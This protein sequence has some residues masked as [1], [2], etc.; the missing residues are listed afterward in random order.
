[1]ASSRFGL[2]SACGWWHP[3]TLSAV[4]AVFLSAVGLSAQAADPTPTPMNPEAEQAL[5]RAREAQ[6]DFEGL[7]RRHLPIS[8]LWTSGECDALVGVDIF[9]EAKEAAQRDRPGVYD[10]Y[11]VAYLTTEEGVG[12][13]ESLPT[14]FNLLV[15]VA[16]L[17]FG[18]IPVDA[19]LNAFN[20][21]EEGAL[22]AF[23]IKDRFLSETDETGFSGAVQGMC[24]ESLELLNTRLYR[25]RVSMSGES[26]NYVA[27]VGRKLRNADPD[28]CLAALA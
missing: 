12:K 5:D 9:P 22:V 18:D 17:G 27:V 28:R 15:T 13:L 2:G 6:E 11:F 23:N 3:A 10:H 20:L 25:H 19:F 7:R 8:A 16:A 24:D 1:M 4:A 26:L 21:L 14:E